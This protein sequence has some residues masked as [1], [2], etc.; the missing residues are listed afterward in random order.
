MKGKERGR[1]GRRK[2]SN[3]E[4]LVE[5]KERVSLRYRNGLQTFLLD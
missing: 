4:G 5:M 2:H 1:K 3:E